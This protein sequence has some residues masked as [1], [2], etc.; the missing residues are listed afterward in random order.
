M[1][2]LTAP[3]AEWRFTAEAPDRWRGRSGMNDGEL[4]QVRR[5]AG[6]AVVVLDI[7]TFLFSRDPSQLG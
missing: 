4:L 5:D 3:G 2:C 1:T 7:A 6:G